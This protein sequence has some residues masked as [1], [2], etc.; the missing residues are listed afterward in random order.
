M[1]KLNDEEIQ[2]LLEGEL[3]SADELLSAGEKESLDQYRFLFEKLKDEPKEGLPYNFASNVKRRVQQ[4]FNRKRD[5]RFYLIAFVVLI[6]GFAG[7]YQVL[8]VVNE[9][10]GARFMD[11]LYKFKWVIFLGAATFLGILYLDQKLVKEGS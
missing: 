6:V 10:A 9:N 11:V 1:K 8:V 5:M 3:K 7:F 2:R 4:Q